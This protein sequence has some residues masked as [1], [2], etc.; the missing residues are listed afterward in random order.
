MTNAEQGR[1]EGD[2]AAEHDSAEGDQRVTSEGDTG[3]PWV[4]LR[5][6]EHATGVAVSTL[7]KWRKR[8]ELESRME[9]GPTG[10]RITVPLEDV[11]RL[12]Q[13]RGAGRPPALAPTA[14][15]AVPEPPAAAPTEPE[16]P[17]WA[18][19]LLARADARTEAL[20]D[21]LRQ[22]EE[23]RA[24]AQR[25]ARIAE[26]KLEMERE[27]VAELER[28]L[29]GVEQ[30]TNPEPTYLGEEPEEDDKL[31]ERRRGE[32]P[33]RLDRTRSWWRDRRR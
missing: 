27:R 2:L 24:D 32:L 8:G 23:E 15:A 30:V 26:H 20:L 25:D 12:A 11:R 19:E 7:R 33:G 31:R 16:P 29:E 17:R 21:R 3:I 18:M 4:T 14:V 5:D 9:P 22:A 28:R 13:Q 6:A 1:A 10:E